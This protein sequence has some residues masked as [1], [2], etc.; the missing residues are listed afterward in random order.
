MS[1]ASCVG[2]PSMYPPAATSTLNSERGIV[3]AAPS[4]VVDV[5]RWCF[6]WQFVEIKDCCKNLI[7]GEKFG[8]SAGGKA[9]RGLE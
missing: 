9:Q 1:A 5:F 6:I 8:E 7:S 4:G 2:T 3:A